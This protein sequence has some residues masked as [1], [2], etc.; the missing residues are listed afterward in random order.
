MVVARGEWNRSGL[1]SI[2]VLADLLIC[3]CGILWLY[4]FVRGSYRNPAFQSEYCIVAAALTLGTGR[5]DFPGEQ[6]FLSGRTLSFCALTLTAVGHPAFPLFLPVLLA[7]SG[8]TVAL[9]WGVLRASPGRDMFIPVMTL[10]G[11]IHWWDQPAI[12]APFVFATLF[13]VCQSM[14]RVLSEFRDWAET[15]V[16]PTSRFRSEYVSNGHSA[17]RTRDSHRP[18]SGNLSLVT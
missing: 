12:C 15:N 14:S 3:S 8:Y 16:M 6:C 13:T 18:H 7:V 9:S 1:R 4:G 2:R 5:K 10:C 17:G 11:A